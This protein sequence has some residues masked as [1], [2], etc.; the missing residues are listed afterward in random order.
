MKRV[1]KSFTMVA[2]Q[3]LHTAVASGDASIVKGMLR[4]GAAI[5]HLDEFGNTPLHRAAWQGDKAIV[6]MLL[7][8][9][10]VADARRKDGRTPLDL[11]EL[12]ARG[13]GDT[14][15]PGLSVEAFRGDFTGVS[16][17]LRDKTPGSD[18]VLQCHVKQSKS[19]RVLLACTNLVGKVVSSVDVDAETETLASTQEA[20]AK[21]LNISQARLRLVMPDARLPTEVENLLPLLHLFGTTTNVIDATEEKCEKHLEMNELS[22]SSLASASTCA[23]EADLTQNQMEFLVQTFECLATNI[24]C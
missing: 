19:G 22:C 3:E 23:S 21:K 9:G 10:A 17:L 18:V 4:A 1:S 24:P 11:V 8:Y 13:A 14:P 5:D 20:M 2:I 6:K 7:K 15:P 12:R 16:T